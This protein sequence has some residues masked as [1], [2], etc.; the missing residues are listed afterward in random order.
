MSDVKITQERLDGLLYIEAKLNALEAGG[1]ENWEGY[2]YTLEALHEAEARK[3]A[4]TE[5]IGHALSDLC[6]E[7]EEPAGSGCGY[8]FMDGAWDIM[9]EAISKAVAIETGDNK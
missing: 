6:V 5:V 9:R 2:S 4:I 1:V 7:V 8:G 3:K